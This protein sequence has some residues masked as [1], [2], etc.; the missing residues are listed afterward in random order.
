MPQDFSLK[1]RAIPAPIVSHD[2]NTIHGQLSPLV[3]TTLSYAW[4]PFSSLVQ[5]THKGGGDVM[6]CGEKV[7]SLGLLIDTKSIM[8]LCK[9]TALK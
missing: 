7:M 6:P 5:R 2:G 4:L 9:G 1:L 3:A 8:V